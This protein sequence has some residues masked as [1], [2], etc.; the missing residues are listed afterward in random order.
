MDLDLNKAFRITESQMNQS[1]DAL[2]QTSRKIEQTSD[3]FD[4]ERA[5]SEGLDS[6]NFVDE[7]N[8][9]NVTAYR[10]DGAQKELDS[11][12]KA[13]LESTRPH[14]AFGQDLSNISESVKQ[15]AAK[16]TSTRKRKLNEE[17]GENKE[18]ALRPIETE[19]APVLKK[20]KL[21]HETA[22]LTISDNR[23][24]QFLE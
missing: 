11:L 13:S 4:F 23:V 6:S 2:G 3:T 1:D 9:E 7:I 16:V 12:L 5:V 24:S 17:N 15:T 21:S 18:N 22:T 14:R 19:E 20:T 10:D 8:T